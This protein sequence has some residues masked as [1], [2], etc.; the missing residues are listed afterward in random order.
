[1]KPISPQ[2]SGGYRLA[3]AHQHPPKTKDEASSRWGSFGDK[4]FVQAQLLKD[5][6][7]LCC[8]SELRADLE[9]LGSQP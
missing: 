6:Y 7:G 4:A 2:N 9:G 5:Q 3:L 1:M 8:Y